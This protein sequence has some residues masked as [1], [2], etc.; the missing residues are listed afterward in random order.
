MI[1][2]SVDSTRYES[3]N[4]KRNFKLGCGGEDEV[5]RRVILEEMYV[6]V[7]HKL[8]IDVNEYHWYFHGAICGILIEDKMMREKQQI[9]KFMSYNLN[10]SK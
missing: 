2:Y 7:Y 4:Q 9:Q 6:I 8:L 5:W 10:T 3:I 1:I